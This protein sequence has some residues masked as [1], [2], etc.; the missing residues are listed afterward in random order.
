M[1]YKE[2]MTLYEVNKPNLI[3]PNLKKTIIL[4]ELTSCK[5]QENINFPILECPILKGVLYKNSMEND[6]QDRWK[7]LLNPKNYNFRPSIGVPITND[8]L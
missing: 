6:Y 4:T 1:T 2:V 5:S 8:H 3:A 7:N